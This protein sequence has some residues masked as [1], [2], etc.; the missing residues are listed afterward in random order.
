MARARRWELSKGI[1]AGVGVISSDRVVKLS[2]DCM[3][4]KFGVKR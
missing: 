2:G 1:L 4:M 3:R